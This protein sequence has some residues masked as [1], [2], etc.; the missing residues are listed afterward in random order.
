[1]KRVNECINFTK[2]QNVESV[3]RKEEQRGKERGAHFN[4]T[5]LQGHKVP[6]FNR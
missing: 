3:T 1:M 6:I 5:E 4:R 2:R